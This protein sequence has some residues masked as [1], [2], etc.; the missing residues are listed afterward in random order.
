MKSLGVV[1]TLDDIDAFELRAYCI[2][3]DEITKQQ[4]LERKKQNGS[5]RNNR[6]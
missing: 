3:E 2:I 4:E 5:R 6:H 1:S